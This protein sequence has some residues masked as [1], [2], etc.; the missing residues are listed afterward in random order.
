MAS[1]VWAI[2]IATLTAMMMSSSQ[3][4]TFV[5]IPAVE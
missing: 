1:I 5:S 2:R 4:I 3:L